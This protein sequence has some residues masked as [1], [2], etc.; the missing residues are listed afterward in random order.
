MIE[1]AS[2]LQDPT[3]PWNRPFAAEIQWVHDL[4]RKAAKTDD[5]KQIAELMPHVFTRSVIRSHVTEL[6][7]SFMKEMRDDHIREQR[8]EIS[9]LEAKRK[10]MTKEVSSQ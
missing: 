6:R 1:D 10:A 5:Q 4:I 9:R 7:R 3:Q 2:Q 8:K